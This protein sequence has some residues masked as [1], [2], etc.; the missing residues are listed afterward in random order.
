MLKI[1]FYDPAKKDVFNV[2]DFLSPYE[3]LG[4]AEILSWQA[5]VLR[6]DAAQLDTPELKDWYAGYLKFLESNHAAGE[7][8]FATFCAMLNKMAD[9]AGDESVSLET[10]E[11]PLRPTPD[12][13]HP[14][15][16][17][18]LG[19]IL[20]SEKPLAPQTAS[21]AF[22]AL[23]WVGIHLR[24]SI[25]VGTEEKWEML[26]NFQFAMEAVQRLANWC[27]ASTKQNIPILCFS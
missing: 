3:L 8:A 27:D 19:Q 22:W 25:A 23:V 24:K 7:E 11:P 2:E 9:M 10:G 6:P 15:A 20:L 17:V 4:L 12:E 14:D 21:D 16:R 26:G 5:E 1:A 13:F 18:L